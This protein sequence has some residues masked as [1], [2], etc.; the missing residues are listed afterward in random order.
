V[1]ENTQA[2]TGADGLRKILVVMDPTRLVQ[3]ALEKAEWI[4]ARNGASLHLFCCIWDS[5]F[6]SDSAASALLI[7]QTDDWLKRIAQS[8]REEGIEAV[9]ETNWDPDWRE[10]IAEAARESEADLIVKSVSRH[11]RVRRQLMRTSDWVVLRDATCPTLLVDNMRPPNPK[12]VLAAV[13]LK[14]SDE[15]HTVL[16]DRVIEMA[17]RITEAFQGELHAVTV[18]RGEDMYFDRQRFADSCKLPRNQVHSAEGQ[19]ARGIA[20]VAERIGAD[21]L[22]IGCAANQVPE[23]GVIIGDTAQRVIDEVTTDIIVIPAG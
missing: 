5:E 3:P 17:H 20:E 9:T 14:P 10:R 22:I 4:A 13:K 15:T 2:A 12:I 1:A 23:R 19:P 16:N 6:A 7:K 8:C 18:Y 11:S 21:V